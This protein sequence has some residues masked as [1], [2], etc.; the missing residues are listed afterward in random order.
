MVL[1]WSCCILP[2]ELRNH[3]H[4]H[5]KRSFL[6]RDNSYAHEIILRQILCSMHVTSHF[7]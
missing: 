3:E 6:G 1:V 4:A 5:E 2:E 7:C